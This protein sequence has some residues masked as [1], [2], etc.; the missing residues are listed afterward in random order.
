MEKAPVLQ[1]GPRFAGG[2]GNPSKI[3]DRPSGATSALRSNPLEG[4]HLHKT[5][6]YHWTT[7]F[8]GVSPIGGS[9]PTRCDKPPTFITT[10]VLDDSLGVEHGDIL[11]EILGNMWRPV[12][13]FLGLVPPAKCPYPIA[14]GSGLG[15]HGAHHTST[16]VGAWRRAPRMGN[17][18]SGPSPSALW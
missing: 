8:L 17:S 7:S 4:R 9:H 2:G 12:N 18:S 15:A 5:V 14:V 16:P 13:P 6:I 1:P 11:R 3:R 10:A